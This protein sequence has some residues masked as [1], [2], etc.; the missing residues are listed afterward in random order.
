MKEECIMIKKAIFGG[1]FDPIH[2]GHLYIAYQALYKLNLDKIIFVPSGNPP[3]KRE[4]VITDSELRYQMI[5][6]AIKDEEKF[7]LS[8]YEIEKRGLSYTH[9]TIAHFKNSE[10]NTEWYFIT[11]VDCLMEIETWKNVKNILS[12]CKFIVFNRPGY[13]ICDILKWK[14]FVQNKYEENIEFLNIPLLD[15]SSTRIKNMIKK[16]QEV[17][18]LLPK[19][20]DAYIR[21]KGLY[22]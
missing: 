18:Y 12:N 17:Y 15:I 2:I 16:G 1:T 5:R 14:D 8:H 7:E 10:K 4:R 13:E 19:G 6:E 9:E 3:H 22:V 20:V 21:H 11:G